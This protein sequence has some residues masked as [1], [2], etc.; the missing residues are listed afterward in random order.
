MPLMDKHALE[1]TV[2]DPEGLHARPAAALV[3]YTNGLPD[4]VNVTL[5]RDGVAADAKSILDIMGL[6]AGPGEK[7]L[8]EVE[9]TKGK[10]D[11]TLVEQIFERTR[12]AVGYTTKREIN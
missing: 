8:V 11:D 6:A 12:A 3:R 10:L 5:R 2:E 4:H 7:L 1:L 9:S